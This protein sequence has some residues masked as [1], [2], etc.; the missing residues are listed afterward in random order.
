MIFEQPVYRALGDC[1]LG[2]EFGDEADLRLSFK[3][4]ALLQALT[5]ANVPGV[6]ELQ[7]TMRQLGVVF[8]RLQTTHAAVQAAVEEALPD[9]LETTR[10][11]SRLVTLPTWYDDPW[12]SALAERFE[13][14]N[15][16]AFVAERNGL[17]VP[18][19]IERH[20]STDWW[21]ALVGFAPGCC[22]TYP[23]D[24]AARVT[25]PKY[26][27]P[28][29]YTPARAVVLA[30]TATAIHPVPSPGGYQVVGRTAVDVYD[31]TL[32]SAA[33]PADGVLTYPG[34]RLRFTAVG[35]LE[36][37][38]IRERIESGT[39]DYDIQPG[40]FDIGDYGA[41]PVAAAAEAIDA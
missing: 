3:V 15:N 37:E 30:G 16:I 35:P 20:Q 33:F 10:I 7:A 5:E 17:T 2:V 38:E 4:I 13:V 19:L 18:E 26:V 34:D 40:V 14:P 12:S 24:P 25:A 21:V 39:Y 32:R 27:V 29:S 28:R 6:I 22:Q 1:Y 8:D 36:Y 31:R 23:L 41:Q 11:P 9:A